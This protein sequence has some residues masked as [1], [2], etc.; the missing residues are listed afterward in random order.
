MK[1]D[2]VN[3]T[4][5]TY[6]LELSFGELTAIVNALEDVHGPEP[7]VDEMKEGIRWYLD[8]LPGPGEDR[9]EFK[10]KK[11]AE[12]DGGLENGEPGEPPSAETISPADLALPSEKGAEMEPGKKDDELDGVLAAPPTE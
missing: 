6:K 12:K 7:I 8:H 5:N 2:K 11:D 4:F 9:E 3:N 1:I 10:A